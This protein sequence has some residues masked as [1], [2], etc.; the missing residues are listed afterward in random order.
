MSTMSD[1]Y[2]SYLSKSEH[3]VLMFSYKL[4]CHRIAEEALFRLQKILPDSMVK[5]LLTAWSICPSV[6]IMQTKGSMVA[7]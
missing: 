4:R 6:R 3:P 5:F 7:Y 1:M 2:E